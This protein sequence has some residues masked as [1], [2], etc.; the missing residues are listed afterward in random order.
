[1][2]SC[3]P[4]ALAAIRAI[5]RRC[6]CSAP[7]SCRAWDDQSK[8]A[9]APELDVDQHEEGQQA[10]P[11]SEAPADQLHFDRQQRCGS[12]RQQV[13]AEVRLRHDA[14]LTERRS[15]RSCPSMTIE[16]AKKHEIPSS[17]LQ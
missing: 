10:E 8:A 5:P 16:G 17:R 11:D 1:M 9:P 4:Y 7:S 3:S 6:R 2:K 14:L 15:R 12:R 13:I